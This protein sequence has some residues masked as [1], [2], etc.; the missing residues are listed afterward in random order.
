MTQFTSP[1]PTE[2]DRPLSAAYT[3]SGGGLRPWS[4]AAIAGFV[5]S[6]LGCVGV[7]AVLGFIFGIIGIVKTK[8]GQRRGLGF[9]IAAIPISLLTAALSVLLG[10]GIIMAISL[11]PLFAE[12]AGALESP[13]AVDA[14]AAVRSICSDSFNEE[15]DEEELKAWLAQIRNTHGNFV[16]L[17]PT[18]TPPAQTAEGSLRFSQTVRFVNGSVSLTVDLVREGLLGFKI[19]DFAVDGLS[20]RQAE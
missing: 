13:H 10:L 9:A 2:N 8:D 17:Q 19:D 14:A 1:L 7:T 4:S 5:L 15:V 18:S 20:P 12:L 11:G 3:A 6:L 16:E